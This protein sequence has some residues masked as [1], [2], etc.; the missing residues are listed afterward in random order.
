MNCLASSAAFDPTTGGS[1][2]R[3]SNIIGLR[4]GLPKDSKMSNFSGISS[5]EDA[6]EENLNQV[7]IKSLGNRRQILVFIMFVKHA[8]AGV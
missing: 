3:P 7:K 1:S 2:F 8:H 6:M 4:D 5:L